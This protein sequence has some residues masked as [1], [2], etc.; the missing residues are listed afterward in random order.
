MEERYV[1][2]QFIIDKKLIKN[3]IKKKLKHPPQENN[4]ITLLI[5][6]H[7]RERYKENFRK[8]IEHYPHTYSNPFIYTVNQQE[9]NKTI[10]ILSKA[11]KPKICAWDYALCTKICHLKISF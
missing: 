2:D 3:I 9:N 7:G 11:G 4:T 10:R 6:G 5:M 8:A 1:F